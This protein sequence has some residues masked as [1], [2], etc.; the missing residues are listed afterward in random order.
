MGANW[1]TDPSDRILCFTRP[2][3]PLLCPLLPPSASRVCPPTFHIVHHP[4][5]TGRKL[6]YA[7]ETVALRQ[8]KGLKG[9]EKRRPADGKASRYLLT[10][11]A[12]GAEIDSCSAS[13]LLTAHTIIEAVSP[14]PPCPCASTGLSKQRSQR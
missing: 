7:P 4:Q 9:L 14:P 6:V 2:E 12:C 5:A 1:P 8:D 10:R 13:H 11:R 3:M